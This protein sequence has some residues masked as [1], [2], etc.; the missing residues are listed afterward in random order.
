L[1]DINIASRMGEIQGHFIPIYDFLLSKSSF[2]FSDMG[3]DLY[4]HISLINNAVNNERADILPI[5][6]S[7]L[8]NALC[9]AD[10]RIRGLPF[11]TR[12][13]AVYHLDSLMRIFYVR[14]I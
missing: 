6:S 1:D 7:Q 4:T 8:Y 11:E 13:E 12:K 5:L 3:K 9:I 10:S 14:S 2:F